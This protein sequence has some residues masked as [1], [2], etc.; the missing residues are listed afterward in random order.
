MNKKQIKEL[1]K[2]EDILLNVLYEE[3]EKLANMEEHFSETERYQDMEQV[4]DELEEIKD[5]LVYF[6]GDL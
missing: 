6:I 1:Q 4:K 5:S 3:E 2:A